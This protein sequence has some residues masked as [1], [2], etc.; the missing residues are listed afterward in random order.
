M[1]VTLPDG[2][3]I[4]GVPDG[5]T[6][7]Q[8]LAKLQANGHPAAAAL[9]HAMAQE[10]VANDPITQGAKNFA[11]DMPFTQQFAAGYGQAV[12]NLVRGMGQIAGLTPQSEVDEAK[13]LD[14]PLLSTGGG[15]LGNIVGNAALYAPSSAIPGAGSLPGAGA[16]G[17][18]TGA[19]QPVGTGESR[20]LNT[21]VGA[22]AG[23]G[24]QLLGRALGR[25]IRPIQTS[26]SPQ[27]EQL[28][29]AAAREGIPLTAGQ[30][31]GSK[32]LQIAESV[33]ENLPLTSGPQL[34]KRE[35]QQRA[36]TAA[37]LSKGGMSGDVADAATLLSQKQGLGGKMA[38][39]ANASSL[40]FNR[41]L[42][43]DLANIVGDADSHLPPDA[44]R[45]VSSVVDKV[46]SQVDQNGNMA[47]TNY[48]GWREPLRAM[49]QDGTA[50]GRYM[51]QIRKALD[52]AFAD[53]AGPDYQGLSRQYANT[54]TIIDAMGGPGKLPATGQVPPA[55]LG[56]ALARSVGKENKTLGVGDLNELSRIG[57]T[58]LKGQIPDSGTAQRQM[59][60]SL[61]TTGGGSL[62]G[63]A[64]A[65][66]TG[67]DPVQGALYGAAAGAGAAAVPRALQ[68]VIN[69][70]AGQAYLTRGVIPIDAA[71]RAALS[72]ALQ[73]TGM[74]AIP[75]LTQ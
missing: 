19:I 49:A 1:D 74:G 12:P 62:V 67:H 33:M 4:Q 64:A 16:I 37:V 46:L 50:E 3:T 10:Q 59:I 26:L 69:S 70:P 8:L 47:G 65:A 55:Q 23:V 54:K 38:Q 41:G 40:D 25:A 53:Q 13:R 32:P 15:V 71:T 48:Q 35:A 75:A 20:A 60:Q 68:M 5:T 58:F 36:F 45:R 73:L 7:A 51:G 31:T 57:Q 24:G 11:K 27:E 52:S 30:Q 39:I 14:Q 42:T 17:A 56:A 22:A 43:T 34:A 21:G 28:A 63:G 18:A 9:G 6:K 44:A 29:Q 2:T 72:K 66:G 61:L